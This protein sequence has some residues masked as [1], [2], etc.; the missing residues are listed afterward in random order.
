[1]TSSMRFPSNP[2]SAMSSAYAAAFEQGFR[3]WAKQTEAWRAAFTR[4]AAWAPAS[5]PAMLPFDR[6]M[7]EMVDALVDS[8]SVQVVEE[9][10]RVA[11]RVTCLDMRIDMMITHLG[12]GESG[13]PDAVDAS[14]LRL[15]AAS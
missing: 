15:G 1:M 5:F 3:A 12:D 14:A 13:R 6:E 11:F 10:D 4:P 7:R 2:M 9:E 8:L